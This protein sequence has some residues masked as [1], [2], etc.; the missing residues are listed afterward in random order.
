MSHDW[1]LRFLRHRIAD[2]RILRLVAKWLK[3]GITEGT[4]VTRSS[5]GA[6]QGAVI[7]PIL[8]NIYLH[9]VFDLWAHA[10][11]QK[12]A[13][14]AVIIIRYADDIVLGFQYEHEAQA[15][16]H[17]MQERMC[18]F[19]LALHP[20][21]T[22]LVRFGRYAAEDRRRLGQGKPETFDFLGFTHFCT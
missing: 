13:S 1:I 14:G 8:A 12:K 20:D 10:W 15:F 6:P 16:L 19:V 5:R 11:R 18:K 21:K 2:K 4:H 3:V 17:D 7:S 22:R 9:Y